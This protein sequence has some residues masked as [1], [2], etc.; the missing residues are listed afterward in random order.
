[1]LVVKVAVVTPPVVVTP[2]VARTVAPS[3]NWTVPVGVATV[4]LPVTVAV[5]VTDCPKTDGFADEATL[6]VVLACVTVNGS[7]VAVAAALL[8]SPLY[9]A[10]KL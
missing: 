3:L 4:V 8:G 7:Q 6:V 2:T 10:L 5:K 9:V 1:V